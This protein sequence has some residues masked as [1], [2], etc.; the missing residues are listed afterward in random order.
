M[1]FRTNSYTV[2]IAVA[3]RRKFSLDYS[4]MATVHAILTKNLLFTVH[5]K[6]TSF[7]QINNTS[8][9]IMLAYNLCKLFIKYSFNILLLIGVT[10]PVPNFLLINKLRSTEPPES[11]SR[12]RIFR[13]K[14]T[15]RLYLG[16]MMA[17]K[18]ISETSEL[19]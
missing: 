1:F 13:C 6:Y 10:L 8:V 15:T 14:Q 17:F 12:V 2:H 18:R 3:L 16:Q 7:E 11:G 4:Y 9:Y 19:M 5:E